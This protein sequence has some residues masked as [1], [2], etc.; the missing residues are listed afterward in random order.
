[1]IPSIS[2]SP[3]LCLAIGFPKRPKDVGLT[4]S[5]ILEDVGGD[6]NLAVRIS[7]VDV[8]CCGLCLDATKP[9]LLA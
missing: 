3:V 7:N 4:A 5:A 1:M 9:E 8:S 6:W 2:R